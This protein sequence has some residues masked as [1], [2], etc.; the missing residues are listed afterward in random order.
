[1]S[2]F[3]LD[4]DPYVF[5]AVG[6]DHHP[7]PR[8]MDWVRG[9]AD[10]RPEPRLLVQSGNTPPPPNVDSR[11]Y[12]DYDDVMETMRRSLGVVCHGGPATIIE[13]RRCGLMPIVVPRRAGLGEHVNDHQWLFS[14]RLAEEGEVRLCETQ[15]EWTEAMVELIESPDSYRVD[16]IGDDHV[17][18]AV[19]TFALLVEPYI[20]RSQERS[21]RRRR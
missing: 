10:V 18:E 4:G 2:G 19:E 11:D 8:L 6:T 14:R 17:A 12:L 9:W 3:R 7:F 5:V 20:L 13:V 1:M 21:R 16:D 15:T